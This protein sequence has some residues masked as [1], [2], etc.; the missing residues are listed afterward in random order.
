ML[1]DRVIVRL[2]LAFWGLGKAAQTSRSQGLCTHNAWNA[3][4]P[5]Y[6]AG[7]SLKAFSDFLTGVITVIV[8]FVVPIMTKS[9]IVYY[10]LMTSC[11]PP[12]KGILPLPQSPRR[13]SPVTIHP[14][15]VVNYPL[16][17]DLCS[18]APC[19]T[20]VVYLLIFK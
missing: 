3:P 13:P 4:A 9:S 1:W 14:L 5:Y 18:D 16:I 20:L 6:Q 19:P 11:I 7:F 10:V 8:S 15:E 17:L 2:V 12:F